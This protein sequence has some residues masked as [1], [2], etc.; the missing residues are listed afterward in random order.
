[1]QLQNHRTEYGI[2]QRGSGQN[3]LPTSRDVRMLLIRAQGTTW[4]MGP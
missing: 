2:R 3:S 1:M 4:L